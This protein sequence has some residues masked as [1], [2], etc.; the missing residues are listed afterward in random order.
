MTLAFNRRLAPCV[1][2]RCPPRMF[3]H[4]LTFIHRYESKGKKIA[5]QQAELLPVGITKESWE[6]MKQEQQKMSNPQVTSN[7]NG[8]KKSGGKKKKPINNDQFEINEPVIGNESALLPSGPN[9]GSSTIANQTK[10]PKATVKSA[11]SAVNGT[12]KTDKIVVAPVEEWV[13]MGKP[14]KGSG[15]AQVYREEAVQSKSSAGKKAQQTN[16]SASIAASRVHDPE[17]DMLI[18]TGADADADVDGSGKTNERQL[19]T[20]KMK[21]LKSKFKEA[22]NLKNLS[23]AGEKLDAS[24]QSKAQKVG[25]FAKEIQ[26]LQNQLQTLKVQS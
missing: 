9:T 10:K 4:A 22:E 8:K 18:D 16:G 25:E 6:K 17:T 13:T 26:V 5:K 15:S 3:T 7:A 1:T 11:T 2:V 20:K 19:L 12:K 23:E 24:Q 14:K 21:K